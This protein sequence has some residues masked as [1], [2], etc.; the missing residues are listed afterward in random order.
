MF[1]LH[2]HL[3]LYQPSPELLA[4]IKLAEFIFAVTTT[5]LA[6]EGNRAR[7]GGLAGVEIGCGLHPELVENRKSE[8]SIL[9]EQIRTTSFV[10][11]VGVD[12]SSAHRHSLPDQT[13]VFTS[14]VRA[15]GRAGGRVVSI[16]S[17]NAVSPILD[18][19]EAEKPVGYPIFHWFSG[20]PAQAL[21]VVK[22]GGYFSVNSA[23]VLSRN[24]RAWINGVPKHLILTETDGPFYTER[25]RPLW[26]GETTGA[27]SALSDV[28]K[29]SLSEAHEQICCNSRNLLKKIGLK[30]GRQ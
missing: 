2:C 8:V 5:P 1:D 24:G 13:R 16:H 7:F 27:I 4:R 23:A 26:P 30:E 15:C 19:L 3:D 14:V 28:W 10:G 25:E 12:G 6:F 29:V 20:T 22:L 18:I 9:L 21:R 17:R 11:E